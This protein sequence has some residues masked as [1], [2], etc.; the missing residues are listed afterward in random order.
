MPRNLNNKNLEM[1]S[2]KDVP[3]DAPERPPP[4]I[5][6]KLE[7]FLRKRRSSSTE[8]A[9]KLNRN[10]EHIP[11]K[12]S[13]S[14]AAKNS[15]CEI[16]GYNRDKTSDTCKEETGN[17][18]E[19]VSKPKPKQR[20][21]QASN[22]EEDQQQLKEEKNR[23]AS[24]NADKVNP[25][26]KSRSRSQEQFDSNNNTNSHVNPQSGTDVTKDTDR[27][28]KEQD[29]SSDKGRKNGQETRVQT[30]QTSRKLSTDHSTPEEPIRSHSLTDEPSDD[31]P[32]KI[33]PKIKP[34]SKSLAN[35]FSSTGEGNFERDETVNSQQPLNAH[36]S[37]KPIKK[38][39]ELQ[40]S[41]SQ[42]PP[43]PKPKT[44][45]K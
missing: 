1:S 39:N 6:E 25:K 18:M 13:P 30:P 29:N 7:E 27:K 12:E 28:T 16:N 15:V 37:P 21:R 32:I 3:K 43:K 8:S 11:L 26:P 4:P 34:R 40:N 31:Q 14:H 5:P 45:V 44:R 23:M 38:P 22:G 17:I 35:V 42:S 2:I 33:R 36:S 19:N 41:L 9:N 10:K 20:H 24:A